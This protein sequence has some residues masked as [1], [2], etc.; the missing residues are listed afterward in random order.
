MAANSIDQL[1]REIIDNE[2]RQKTQQTFLLSNRIRQRQLKWLV[3]VLRTSD[4]RI[5]TTVAAKWNRSTRTLS[6]IQTEDVRRADIS[7]LGKQQKN[8]E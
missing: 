5:T 2:I 8:E 1:R 3:H 7:M 4:D 6:K